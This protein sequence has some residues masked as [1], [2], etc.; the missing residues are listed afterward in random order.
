MKCNNCGFN[1]E[2]GVNFCSNCGSPL[3]NNQF[4]HDIDDNLNINTNT[5]S[6]YDNVEPVYYEESKDSG[7]FWW[8]VLGF[9]F[10]L[11]G[12]IL[13]FVW[14]NERPMTAKKLLIGAIVS[15]ALPVVIGIIFYLIAWPGV[16]NT[17]VQQTCYT[18]GMD[19]KAVKHEKGWACCPNNATTYSSSCIDA[20]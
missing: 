18:Y 2:M 10:P 9:F 4:N 15:I 12:I 8:G 11:I 14:K 6:Q 3:N 13:Y 19:Y 7:S 17:V 5:N 16:Q 20:K 1:N